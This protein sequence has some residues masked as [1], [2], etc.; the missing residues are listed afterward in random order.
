MN[1]RLQKVLAAAGVGSRRRCEVL[2]A[3][4][5][6]RVNGAIVDRPGT[7]VDV[8]VDEITVDGAPVEQ[9]AHH[10]VILYKPKGFVCS[11][12][13]ERGKPSALD[14]VRLP[15]GERMFCVGRLDEESHGL[16]I[17]TNDGDFANRLTHPRYG[18]AKTYRVSVKGRA[19]GPLLAKVQRGVWLAEGKTAPARVQ[20]VKR[21]REMSILKVTL[22]EGRNR[23]LRRVFARLGLPV[24]DI[25]RV[26]IGPLLLGRMRPGDW[27]ELL[28]REVNLLRKSAGSAAS[29][30][31]PGPSALE[32]EPADRD[33]E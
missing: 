5:R 14:L 24:L 4:R 33:D 1:E 26:Q 23:H 8:A 25:L 21:F 6:V 15:S 13:P 28:P 3:E 16:L 27:R 9:Q 17:L 2:I 22:S 10:Y 32:A 11:A 19:D 30:A 18:V 29:R 20:V 12:R 7:K 31:T